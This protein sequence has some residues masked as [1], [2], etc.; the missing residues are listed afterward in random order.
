ME[1]L[2]LVISLLCLALPLTLGLGRKTALI[3][4]E[5]LIGGKYNIGARRRC[6]YTTPIIVNVL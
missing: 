5:Y 6:T 2:A 1:P 4:L 3:D